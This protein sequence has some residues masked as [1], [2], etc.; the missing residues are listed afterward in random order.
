MR[1]QSPARPR[2][3]A[4]PFVVIVFIVL[5]HLF[6]AVQM[7]AQDRREEG[8]RRQEGPLVLSPFAGPESGTA[9]ALA[10]NITRSLDVSLRLAADSS[11]DFADFILP[12]VAFDRAEIY[13]DKV[14]ASRAVFGTVTAEDEGYVVRAGLWTADDAGRP[15]TREYRVESAL[16]VFEVADRLAVEIAS[17]V[18]GRELAFGTV[19]VTNADALPAFAVYVD[20]NLTARNSA[21]V[22]V[23]AG[24]RRVIVARPGELGDEPVQQFDL[25][26]P[27]D[28]RVSVTLDI[29]DR[30]DGETAAATDAADA[31]TGDEARQEARPSDGEAAA[32]T[33]WPATIPTGRLVVESQPDGAEVLLDDRVIGTT[34]LN[35]FGVPEG[36][37]ELVVRR[38]W[39][40]PVTQVVDVTANQDNAVTTDLEVDPD[41]PE[42]AEHLVNP[43]GASIAALGMTALQAGLGALSPFAF[44]WPGDGR[45]TS[46]GMMNA[47]TMN[48]QLVIKAGLL[49]PGHAI[50]APSRERRIVNAT[51]VALSSAF[52]AA[53]VAYEYWRENPPDEYER[54]KPIWDAVY[55]GAIV[56][57]LGVA[58]LELYDIAFVP[59]AGRRRNAATLAEID[60][61]GSLPEEMRREPGGIA[62]E[63]GGGGVARAGYTFG[64]IRHYLYGHASA[65]VAL[66]GVEP[67][68]VGP[69]LL[70][71][72]DVYPMGARSGA[73]R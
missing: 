17:A 4:L 2:S 23:L 41:H 9:A 44:R 21:D 15:E 31:S 48:L 26:V 3:R 55:N 14:Q 16:E 38:Q 34:P 64:I 13:Y 66:T 60:R 59:A 50:A 68:T 1:S 70:L 67:L 24:E 10:E 7:P 39:F 40:I 51:S 37:Y 45:L 30:D 71:R 57:A 27:P 8:D 62:V 56:A 65:G 11:V 54:E 63:V 25:T 61:T 43:G 20:G 35:R 46:V 58:A 73:F 47:L 12:H 28:D 32:V 42:V 5:V 53:Q 36:R 69:N 49:R 22:R 29:V 6:V 18:V 52:L 19:R 33:G 72:L